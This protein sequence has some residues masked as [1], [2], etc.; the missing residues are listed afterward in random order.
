IALLGATTV[1]IAI[2]TLLGVATWSG[3]KRYA[4][5]T[6]GC[7]A[8]S[9]ANPYG[10]RLHVHVFQY[11]RSDWI[12]SVI[13]EFQAPTFRNENLMQYE[14]LMLIGV[15]VTG[16]LFRRKQIAE[17]LWILFFAHMSLTTVRH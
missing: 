1:G 8:A 3:V 7:A 12:R 6:A 17:G 11:L 9:L 2:E 13:Q 4:L 10:Y 14:A 5:L 16:S 15:L